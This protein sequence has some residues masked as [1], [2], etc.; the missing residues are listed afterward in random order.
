[1]PIRSESLEG[2][3]SLHHDPASP[4]S[5]MQSGFPQVPETQWDQPP[6]LVLGR[7]SGRIRNTSTPPLYKG[8]GEATVFPQPKRAEFIRIQLADGTEHIERYDPKRHG[9]LTD[10]PSIGL[11]P[12]ELL[13]QLTGFGVEIIDQG[14]QFTRERKKKGGA[15]RK[16]WPARHHPKPRKITRV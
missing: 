5:I 9:I 8:S 15:S 7:I 13:E 6:V 11:L 16:H 1:M 4:D 3:I 10:I 14:Q 12:Q 2:R